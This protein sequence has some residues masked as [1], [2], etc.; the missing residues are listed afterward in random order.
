MELAQRLNTVA[1]Q[2]NKPPQAPDMQVRYLDAKTAAEARAQGA[3]INIGE[4]NGTA[5]DA[6]KYF[7]ETG[8]TPE[9]LEA[10]GKLSLRKQVAKQG[11]ALSRLSDPLFHDVVHGLLP[12]ERAAVIGAGVPNHADQAALYTLMRQREANGK[13]LTDDQVGE[14]VRM[15][16]RTS[17][18]TQ[19]SGDDAQGGLFGVEEM[20][21]SL[22]P[23]KAIVSDYVRKQLGAEKKLF[24]AVS[25]QA[26]AD[27][28]GEPATSS[29][30]ALMRKR[31][32]ML[33][34]ARNCTISSVPRPGPIDGVLDRAA[35]ALAKGEN[36]ND[37]KQ[38]PTAKSGT[39]S[40][41]SSMS[42]EDLVSELKACVRSGAAKLDPENEIQWTPEELASMTPAERARCVPEK[43]R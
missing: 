27:R 1:D 26:A 28:L 40:K 31:P 41:G 2:S 11:A 7:R 33:M 32:R 15:N 25:T 6:A 16:Q 24:G 21:R 34:P 14:L 39:T 19:N 30:P 17:T 3:T 29:R 23:E 20:T 8:Q 13:R 35:Q 37:I 22:L 43:A 42:C 38:P 10:E 5:I 36:A 9:T 4:G 12:V 18:V